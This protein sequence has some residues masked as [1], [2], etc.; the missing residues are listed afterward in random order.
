MWAHSWR[1]SRGA[2]GR[3]PRLA[4]TRVSVPC[5]P[6][7]ASSLH[8]G[9]AVNGSVAFASPIL[10]DGASARR[11]VGAYRVSQLRLL[12]LTCGRA[13]SSVPHHN[14]SCTRRSPGETRP[15]RNAAALCHQRRRR[16]RSP[17][18]RRRMLPVA[19]PVFLCGDCCL[20]PDLGASRYHTRLC[21]APER[22]QQFARHGY[23]GDPPCAPGQ[24][25]D[26]LSEPLC[27]LAARLVAKPEPCE[28]D[29]SRPCARVSSPANA[30]IAIHAAALVGHWC[31]ADVA[32]DL[33]AV[34]K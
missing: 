33:P 11:W 20:R 34:V 15:T 10:I 9:S 13:R 32:R 31:D 22:Y 29:H 3:V 14:A 6:M 25:A 7:R 28:L 8:E 27:Q 30:P 16:S 21:V 26:A 24:R 17:Y 12:H 19:I 5:W 4:Q 1:W 2:R 23:N 18:R